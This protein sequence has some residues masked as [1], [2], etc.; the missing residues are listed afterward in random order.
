MA[1]EQD[2]ALAGKELEDALQALLAI[3]H[4]EKVEAFLVGP[5][6]RGSDEVGEAAG[7]IEIERGGV[8]F[9]LEGGGHLDDLVEE[10]QDLAGDG[11]FLGVGVDFFLKG[12]EAGAEEGLGSGELAQKD[13]RAGVDQETDVAV[14]QMEH[15][16]DGGDDGDGMQ[17]L[18]AKVGAGRLGRVRKGKE[19]VGGEDRVDQGHIA[20]VGDGKAGK[21]IGKSDE[22]HREYGELFRKGEIFLVLQ[23]V[24]RNLHN[25]T[26]LERA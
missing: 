10:L 8:H 20:R 9:V 25:Y 14:G 22:G 19:P 15:L 1:Q 7:M 24:G 3:E 21:H 17:F 11:L 5:A 26:V 18:G 13:A 16:H 4:I 6:H 12:I 2:F 23:A